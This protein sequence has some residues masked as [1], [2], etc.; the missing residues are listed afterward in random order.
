MRQWRIEG[1]FVYLQDFASWA[2]EPDLQLH[3]R[4]FGG[5][6]PLCSVGDGSLLS[7]DDRLRDDEIEEARLEASEEGLELGGVGS[8]MSRWY[9]STIS[10]Y[11]VLRLPFFS[12][13]PL[14]G[15]DCG[16]LK[17]AR[18]SWTAKGF[19]LNDGA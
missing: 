8:S 18:I 11:G 14:C 5:E 15:F 7:C 1:D 9:S 6:R 2:R 17:R 16:V 19:S 12:N 3:A 10:S 4:S 13:A